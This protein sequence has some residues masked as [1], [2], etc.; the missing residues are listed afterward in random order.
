MNHLTEVVAS[1]TRSRGRTNLYHVTRA[2]NL[3]HIADTDSLLSSDLL[4]PQLSGIRRH[5]PTIVDYE[6][7]QVTLN[8][9][10]RIP[11]AMMAPGVSDTAFHAYLDKHVFCWLTKRDCWHMVESYTRREPTL[12]LAVMELDAAALL[13]D[14]E[15]RVKLSKYDSGSA[16][17]YPG[18]CSYRKSP[19]MFVS[20]SSFGQIE[21]QGKPMKPSEIREVLIEDKIE[22]VSSY[23]N[24]FYCDDMGAIPGGWDAIYR[25]MSALKP[26]AMDN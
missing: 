10:L 18:R 12:T 25:P 19:E 9:H 24:A 17:R 15:G 20:L 4:A 7:R 22:R 16:P 5:K 26:G 3:A 21:G 11:E 14:Y 23:I 6:G 13:M 8:A 1:I 2:A